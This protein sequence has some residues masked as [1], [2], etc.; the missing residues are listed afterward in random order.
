MKL[1]SLFVTHR[2]RS[3]SPHLSVYIAQLSSVFSIFHRVSGVVLSIL[4]LFFFIVFSCLSFFCLTSFVVP[5]FFD[6]SYIYVF[7]SFAFFIVPLFC[8]SYHI[9]CG[10]RN[11]YFDFS[12]QLTRF[13]VSFLSWFILFFSFIFFFSCIFPV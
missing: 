2:S 5:L 8:L 9:F 11:L 6:F 1:S 13:M 4:L 12:G 3:L 7:F 10:L